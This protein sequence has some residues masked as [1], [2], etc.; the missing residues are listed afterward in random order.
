M[1]SLNKTN[2]VPDPIA[3]QLIT[4]GTAAVK[5]SVIDMSTKFSMSVFW[6]FSPAA[7]TAGATSTQLSMQGSFKDA[8]DDA[9]VP[10]QDWLSPTAQSAAGALA[11]DATPLSPQ[12]IS[13]AANISPNTYILFYEAGVIANSEWA[14]VVANAGG[15][16]P[17]YTLTLEQTLVRNHTIVN[18]VVHSYA[19]RWKFD[20]DLSTIKRVRFCL[21]NSRGATNRDVVCRVGLTTLDSI[22]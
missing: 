9:W 4:A 22:A 6:D 18:T 14:F 3:I 12:T 19:A 8:G 1:S 2:V 16:G 20:I 13:V 7:N 10:L 17:N 15:G 5:S 21:F 11:V